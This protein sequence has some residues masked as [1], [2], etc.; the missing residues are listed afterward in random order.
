M[1]GQQ[2]HHHTARKETRSK[3]PAWFA[4]ASP[5]ILF[6]LRRCSNRGPA[7]RM[8][9]GGN[10][11]AVDQLEALPLS[12]AS[13]AFHPRAPFAC[14]ASK[15]QA[16]ARSSSRTFCAWLAACSAIRRQSA[17]WPRKSTGV[18][19]ARFLCF[20]PGERLWTPVGDT[21][22]QHRYGCGSYDSVK[23]RSGA[24]HGRHLRRPPG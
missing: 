21:R 16:C 12:E 13:G 2:A 19:T 6:L 8:H 18:L 3:A 24:T 15:T 14:S 22:L 10:L 1:R 7:P 23:M 4:W 9:P 17:T 20:D 11:L 5:Y